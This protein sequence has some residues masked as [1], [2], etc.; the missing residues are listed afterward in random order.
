MLAGFVKAASQRT[1]TEQKRNGAAMETSRVL[2][3]PP[4]PPPG[5]PLGGPTLPPAALP[6]PRPQYPTLSLEEAM[7]TPPFI[8]PPADAQQR[9]S[10]VEDSADSPSTQETH[11]R[12][13]DSES[14]SPADDVA[15]HE[16][17]ARDTVTP[18]DITHQPE[19]TSD[20]D[21]VL[22]HT[23]ASTPVSSDNTSDDFGVVPIDTEDWDDERRAG[24]SLEARVQRELLRR[25][26]AESTTAL[27]APQAGPSS[28][29]QHSPRLRT[30]QG[31]YHNHPIVG[32][33]EPPVH[34]ISEQTPRSSP[35]GS[36]KGGKWKRLFIPTVAHSSDPTPSSPTISSPRSPRFGFLSAG[37]TSTL[38]LSAGPSPSPS[39][40]FA[41][42]S[43]PA[44]KK[45]HSVV[46]RLFSPKGKDRQVQT[47]PEQRNPRDS[48]ECWEV[49]E[50]EV[51]EGR[52][53]QASVAQNSQDLPETQEPSDIESEEEDNDTDSTIRRAPDRHES[54]I[55]ERGS[56]ASYVGSYHEDSARRELVQVPLALRHQPNNNLRAHIALSGRPLRRDVQDSTPFPMSSS[57]SSAISLPLVGRTQGHDHPSSIDAANSDP[58]RTESPI[59]TRRKALS[60]V[61]ASPPIVWV[62]V[63]AGTAGTPPMASSSS[64]PLRSPGP[65][66]LAL[67]TGDNYIRRDVGH[68]RNPSAPATMSYATSRLAHVVTSP[69]AF[70]TTSDPDFSP[71][72]TSTE[73]PLEEEE[74]RNG[75]LVR[76]GTLRSPASVSTLASQSDP[77]STPT[78]PS[79]HYRGRPLPQP[80]GPSFPFERVGHTPFIRPGHLPGQV[81]PVSHEYVP[82]TDLDL[83]AAQLIEEDHDGR[84]YEVLFRL[85]AVDKHLSNSPLVGSSPDF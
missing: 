68:T 34:H 58:E 50:R 43:L 3:R 57:N 15:S 6:D 13:A 80:P 45:E 12:E 55:V 77:P 63:I 35:P 69:L 85:R 24:V 66:R 51:E 82:V 8:P 31:E 18:P 5:W 73:S 48:M 42:G 38:T 46:R 70:S 65:S 83:V 10:P 40:P 19:I 76:R 9:P 84:N 59:A 1:L 49:V 44:H 52:S 30:H 21:R 72:P 22:P 11:E 37:L 41:N 62:P 4:Q 74:L 64:L 81:V 54:L 20:V 23:Q 79:H 7:M 29:G 14:S 2:T 28:D 56:W 71:S 53:S 39:K 25:Q 36:P 60:T 33:S 61:K 27:V 26:A 67:R 17:I 78:T 32:Q 75:P 47:A 16:I